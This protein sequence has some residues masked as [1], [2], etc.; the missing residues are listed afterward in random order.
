M[1]FMPSEKFS[2]KKLTKKVVKQ[3][4][5]VGLAGLAVVYGENPYYIAIAPFLT[6]LD[7]AISH[8]ND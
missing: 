4:V 2:W 7:N 5:I 1:G 8:W 3:I 6:A